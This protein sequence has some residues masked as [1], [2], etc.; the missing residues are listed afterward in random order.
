[1][2]FVRIRF[3]CDYCPYA[4]NKKSNCSMHMRCVHLGEKFSC[5]VCNKKVAN[6]NQH[7]RMAHKV[8]RTQGEHCSLC[9]KSTHNLESHNSKTHNIRDAL[10][11]AGIKML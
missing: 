9:N 8:F 6:L 3:K 10:N 4:T 1:M 2:I 11:E 7:M 5:Q